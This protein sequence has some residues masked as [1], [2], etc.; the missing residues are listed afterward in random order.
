MRQVLFYIPLKADWLPANLPLYVVLL[1]VG[2]GL[3]LIAWLLARRATRPALQE[4][5]RGASYWLAGFGI[6]SALVVYLGADKLTSGLPIYGFGMMLFLAFILCTWLAARRAD[7]E[8]VAR[9]HIQDLTIWLFI[10][11]LIGARIT[12]LKFEKNMSFSEMAQ[13]FYRIWDGGIVLY[14]SVIG[15]LVGYA[16]AYVLIFRK[17]KLSTLKLADIVAPSIAVGLCLGRFG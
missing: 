15:G 9:E 12:Y 16:V 14:G 4:G 2:L 6:V 13:E 7:R 5:L 3:G 11:G 10:G 8:G 1:A 17:Y